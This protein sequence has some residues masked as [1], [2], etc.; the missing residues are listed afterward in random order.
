MPSTIE[1]DPLLELAIPAGD[2]FRYAE[3]RRLFYV[4]LTRA[5]RQV[6]LLTLL[7]R[8]SPYIVELVNDGHVTIESASGEPIK[9]IPRP[10]CRT[11][12]MVNRTSRY[13]DF[14]G[15]SNFPSCNQTIN[16]I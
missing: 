5:R 4:A 13:G 9:D 8:E 10:K 11:G 2:N 15:F 14:P 12:R 6:L 1:D 16:Q 7:Y 3:E